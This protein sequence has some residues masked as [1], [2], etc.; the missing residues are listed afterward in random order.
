MV[1][2]VVFV[3]GGPGAGKGTQCANIV[4]VTHY[5]QPMKELIT[6]FIVGEEIWFC[7]SFCWRL[8]KTRESST[9]FRIWSIN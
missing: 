1:P 5:S 2:K 6:D 9:G 7:S 3:L 8:V 4:Q